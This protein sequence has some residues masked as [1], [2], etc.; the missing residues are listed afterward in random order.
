MTVKHTK[1][2]VIVA[3]PAKPPRVIVDGIP[4][5]GDPDVEITRDV[6]LELGSWW[7]PGI[8]LPTYRAPFVVRLTFRDPEIDIQLIDPP[9][10]VTPTSTG[11]CLT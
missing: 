7:E 3:D 2:R 5:L 9:A 6:R 11:E 4:V 10:A 8:P 1:I